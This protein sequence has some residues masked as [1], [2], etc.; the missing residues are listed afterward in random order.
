VLYYRA[1]PHAKLPF[2]DPIAGENGVYDQRDNAAFTGSDVGAVTDYL[3]IREEKPHPFG[4]LGFDAG[5]PDQRP[6]DDSFAGQVY[7]RGIFGNETTGR[8]WPQRAQ[9][10][11]L[12][13]PGPDGLWGTKDDI[14]N[15]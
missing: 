5:V 3:V 7:D 15:Y 8:V 2:T 1:S 12:V 6:E 4:I 13:S 9:T 11:L 10:F 14:A